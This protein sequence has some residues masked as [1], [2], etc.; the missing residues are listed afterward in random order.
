MRQPH[1][2]APA[3]TCVFTW[4]MLAASAGSAEAPAE[5]SQPSQPSPPPEPG[6][7]DHGAPGAWLRWY[8]AEYVSVIALGAVYATDLTGGLEP[9][10]ALM[11]PSFDLE[12][13]DTASLLDPRLDGVIGAPLLHEKVPPA[14]MAVAVLVPVGVEVGLDFALHRDL[15][16]THALVLGV[17]EAAVGAAV[18]TDLIRLSVGRLRP[19]FRERWVRAACGGVVERP[20]ELDC[21]GVD[22]GFVV[23]RHMLIEGMKSF[24]SLHTSQSFAAA[25]FLSLA[26]GS[27]HLWGKDAPTWVRPLGALAVATLLGGA[28]AVAATRVEDHRHHLE[29]VAVGAAIGVA[30]GAAAWL[31]HFDLEGQ[32][33][34]RGMAV[35]ALP[36][37]GGAGVAVN[38]AF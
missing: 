4:L 22:D 20:A 14:A 28:S 8:G 15:H 34:Q 24:P 23:D 12:R 7:F 17:A 1:R 5:P 30:S 16:R 35:T 36:L 21:D 26:V 25:T 2:P 37:A 9:L 11:G 3:P 18:V 13:P 10:P 31:V 32:A 29:D 33:R 19:D 6:F 27:E 38:A